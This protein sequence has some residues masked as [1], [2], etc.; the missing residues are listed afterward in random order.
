MKQK[1]SYKIWTLQHN[2]TKRVP[3]SGRRVRDPLIVSQE[4]YINTKLI[5]LVYMQESSCRLV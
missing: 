5:A 4:S 3:N 1:L 2:W